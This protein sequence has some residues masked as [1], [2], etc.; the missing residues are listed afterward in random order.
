MTPSSKRKITEFHVAYLN[1][2]QAD[3]RT[4]D[5]RKHFTNLSV[6][7]LVNCYFNICVSV[8]RVK[9]FSRLSGPILDRIDI[10]IEVP[11]VERISPGN[12]PS[13]D[14]S[15]AIRLRVIVARQM[16]QERFRE[17]GWCCN[18][19]ATGTWLRANTSPKAIELVNRALASERLSLRGADRA[20]RLAW[21]LSD[22][23]GKTSPGPEE[24]MQGISMRTRLA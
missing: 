2:L 22:L 12:A 16:A 23:A 5:C 18:A 4:A 20:M 14:S 3:N 6:F 11:P 24:M 7:T 9:Y 19:Q 15:H 21:T 1:S 10:Q 17:F 8:Y 13:G